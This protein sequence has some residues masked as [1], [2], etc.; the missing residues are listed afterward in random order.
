MEETAVLAAA[1]ALNTGSQ[2]HHA[3]C[4]SIGGPHS[5]SAKWLTNDL[6]FCRGGNSLCAAHPVNL[7]AR[8][9]HFIHIRKHADGPNENT[10]N[11][12][13]NKP[14]FPRIA[15]T[16]ESNQVAQIGIAPF[17]ELK[18]HLMYRLKCGPASP[19][20]DISTTAQ[21]PSN[22]HPW[23]WVLVTGDTRQRSIANVHVLLRATMIAWW[24]RAPCFLSRRVNLSRSQASGGQ[25]KWDSAVSA[26]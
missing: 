5:E 13:S 4:D 15:A 1:V 16:P 25:R 20:V 9:A 7:I 6:R 8:S 11:C 3:S 22:P 14:I 23:R 21:I 19:C 10:E 2:S 18:L 26:A 24:K 12:S 17:V